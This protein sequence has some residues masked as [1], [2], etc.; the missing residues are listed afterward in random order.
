MSNPFITTPRTNKFPENFAAK[1]RAANPTLT[2]YNPIYAE[3][4][5]P[6]IHSIMKVPS[7]R[8]FTTVA[9]GRSV[10]TMYLYVIRAWQWLCDNDNTPEKFYSLAKRHVKVVKNFEQG[11]VQIVWKNRALARPES[12]AV[13][14]LAVTPPTPGAGIP[15]KPATW[16]K[17][18]DD[19]VDNENAKGRLVLEELGLSNEDMLFVRAS[20]AGV[21]GVTVVECTMMKLVVEKR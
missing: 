20:L 9:T 4:L 7:T 5:R 16:R 2:Y 12:G 1:R 8:T 11:Y 18:L 10:W 13:A 17:E 6:V 15:P 3:A 19:F 21:A 14:L